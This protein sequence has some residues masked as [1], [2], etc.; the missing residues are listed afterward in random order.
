MLFIHINDEYFFR[1][2]ITSNKKQ[3]PTS[4]SGSQWSI[5]LCVVFISPKT[6][7]W[8]KKNKKK[9]M[10]FDFIYK[11]L[12]LKKAIITL[13]RSLQFHNLLFF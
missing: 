13:N 3:I 6:I 5:S 9:N 2:D 4:S 11:V 7:T 10:L 12:F 8:L 1:N